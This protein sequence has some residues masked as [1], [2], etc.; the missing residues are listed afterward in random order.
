MLMRGFVE[1]WYSAYSSVL[2][3]RVVELGKWNI[4]TV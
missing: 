1:S 2:Y 4:G 3:S